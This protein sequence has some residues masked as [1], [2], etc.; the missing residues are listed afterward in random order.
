MTKRPKKDIDERLQ[1][2]HVFA[3]LVRRLDEWRSWARFV[4]DGGGPIGKLSDDDLRAMV[5]ARADAGRHAAEKAPELL[6]ALTQLANEVSGWDV[7]ALRAFGGH[8]NTTV[9]LTR[10]DEARALITEI[11]K[12]AA[13][14]AQETKR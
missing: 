6:V 5:C 2:P 7:A 14:P 12:G 11:E 8:T 1:T 4:F 13:G 10:R 9:L 3:E